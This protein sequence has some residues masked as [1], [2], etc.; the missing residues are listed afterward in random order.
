MRSCLDDVDKAHRKAYEDR[1][2][3]GYGKAV[4]KM[5]LQ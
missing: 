5:D 2:C 3:H 4:K 1:T